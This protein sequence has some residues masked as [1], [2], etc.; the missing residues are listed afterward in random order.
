MYLENIPD[1]FWVSPHSL[2]L[3]DEEAEVQNISFIQKLKG[4]QKPQI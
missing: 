4:Q 2:G 1:Y 3:A